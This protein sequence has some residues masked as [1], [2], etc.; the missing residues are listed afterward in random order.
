[1]QPVIRFDHTILSCALDTI[2]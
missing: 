2:W 1:M